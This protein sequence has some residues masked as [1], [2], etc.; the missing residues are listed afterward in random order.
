MTDTRPL[1]T[2]IGPTENALRALLTKTLSTS[3][4]K[5]Y[6]AWVV[7]NAANRADAAASTGS[8]Q[9]AVGDALKVDRGVV[10]E[11]LAQLSTDGLVGVSGSLTPIGA[12]ELAAARSAVAGTTAQLVEGISEEEQA[13]ARRVLEQL[14]RK[15]EDLLSL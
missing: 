13:V 5:T 4:I 10:N 12:A 9:H 2:V 7:L 8:W 14:R 11:V 15:A 6:Q 3:K 1:P